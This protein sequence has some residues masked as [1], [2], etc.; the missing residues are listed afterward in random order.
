MEIYRYVPEES[1]D[2]NILELDWDEFLNLYAKA[3]YMRKI[4]RNDFK[5]AVIEALSKDK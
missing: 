2:G 4:E 3:R 5:I 1:R